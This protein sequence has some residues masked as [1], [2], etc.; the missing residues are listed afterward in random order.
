MNEEDDDA[1]VHWV[2]N[3]RYEQPFELQALFTIA[4][5][6]SSLQP[7]QKPFSGSQ[8]LIPCLVSLLDNGKTAP[9][10]AS[11][12]LTC[13]F[14]QQCHNASANLLLSWHYNNIQAPFMVDDAIL[15]LVQ[16]VVIS[17]QDA[18]GDL[19]GGMAGHGMRPI[20]RRQRIMQSR[21]TR[22][23][24]ESQAAAAIAAG[25]AAPSSQ[26]RYHTNC[27]SAYKSFI[28]EKS[29]VLPYLHVL[30]GLAKP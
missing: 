30:P 27:M 11:T 3:S 24:G 5:L 25:P 18:V 9:R 10:L 23:L 1:V 7:L 20:N 29:L 13:C 4:A 26:H 12:D 16:A 21:G 19:L 15:Y 8:H 28:L 14:K 22:A 2:S 17:V 6:A